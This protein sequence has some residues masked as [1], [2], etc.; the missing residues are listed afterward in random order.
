MEASSSMDSSQ[1]LAALEESSRPRDTR[2]NAAVLHDVAA[3]QAAL[4]AMPLPHCSDVRT[5][6]FAADWKAS[7]GLLGE[8]SKRVI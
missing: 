6:S 5:G 1:D 3:L 4:A 7:Q 2:S 8:R